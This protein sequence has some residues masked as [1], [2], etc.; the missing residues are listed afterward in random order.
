MKEARI[1]KEHIYYGETSARCRP[2]GSAGDARPG[3][4]AAPAPSKTAGMK[5][6]ALDDVAEVDR[7]SRVHRLESK[8][9][10]VKKHPSRYFHEHT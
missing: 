9:E 4:S 5:S 8:R 6:C 10:S 7:L 3:H 2:L 1:T